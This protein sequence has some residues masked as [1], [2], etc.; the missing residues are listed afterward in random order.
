MFQQT[1]KLV[2]GREFLGIEVVE[3]NIGVEEGYG[4]S[5]SGGVSDDGAGLHKL[6]EG[7]SFEEG[8][9]EEVSL[10]VGKCEKLGRKRYGEK[11]KGF[12]LIL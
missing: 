7:N 6:R 8:G 3:G 2:V 1:V 5:D 12:S 10:K 9:K 4:I 11:S